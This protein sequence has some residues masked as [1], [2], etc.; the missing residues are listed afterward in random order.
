[1][2]T[3]IWQW[4]FRTNPTWDQ[5]R[6]AVMLRGERRGQEVISR[7][8]PGKD[9]DNLASWQQAWMAAGGN[10]AQMRVC[11]TAEMHADIDDKHAVDGFGSSPGYYVTISGRHRTKSSK[12]ECALQ[13]CQDHIASEPVPALIQ[14]VEELLREGYVTMAGDDF[15]A[16]GADPADEVVKRIQHLIAEI[17]E[18]QC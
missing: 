5:L 7:V 1:M 6:A 17:K 16:R 10:L 13:L 14:A 4:I 11:A 8:G 15:C 2:L 9:Y 18:N 3:R 12:I